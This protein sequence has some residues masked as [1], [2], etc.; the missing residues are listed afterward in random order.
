MPPSSDL[1]DI[2]L[3]RKESQARCDEV[4]ADINRLVLGSRASIKSSRALMAAADK[5]LARS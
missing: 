2:R 1:Q 3:I 4:S 5:L